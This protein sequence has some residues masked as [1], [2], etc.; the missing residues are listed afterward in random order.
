M[1]AIGDWIFWTVCVA[2]A[3]VMLA[4]VFVP[5]SWVE[6]WKRHR[7][8]SGDPQ[9]RAIMRAAGKLRK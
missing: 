7:R 3:I 4:G 8:L 2:F 1:S 6:R 5:N 9:A